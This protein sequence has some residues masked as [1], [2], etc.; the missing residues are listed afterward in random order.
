MDVHMRCKLNCGRYT[1]EPGVD[2]VGG[3][4]RPRGLQVAFGTPLGEVNL[5]HIIRHVGRITF[6]ARRTFAASHCCGVDNA[7]GNRVTLQ[8]HLDAGAEVVASS[9][10]KELV[11][12]AQQAPNCWSE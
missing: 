6:A 1:P 3:S 4:F 10:E 5:P 9:N 11:L 7:R 8:P 12:I 2:N